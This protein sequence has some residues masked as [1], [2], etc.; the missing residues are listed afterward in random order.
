MDAI[1]YPK[2]SYSTQ[3]AFTL[4]ELLTVIAIIAILAVILIPTLGRVRQVTDKANCASNLRQ[5]GVGIITFASDNDG[6]LP[7]GVEPR[8]QWNL[9]GIQAYAGPQGWMEGGK[10]TQDLAAQIYRYVV[11]P[12]T[13]SKLP[14]VEVL[15]CP[16]NRLAT[17][18]YAKGNSLSSYHTGTGVVVTGG[19][20]KRPFGK[21]TGTRAVNMSEVVSLSRSVA[22]YDVDNEIQVN[23]GEN[24]RSDIPQHANEVHGNSRNFLYLD[25]HV[26]AQ[27]L[28]YKPDWIKW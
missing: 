19:E 16:G 17:D 28:D 20:I 8:G 18:A 15:V 24:A 23:L 27:P 4:I 3:S 7:G 13:S 22:L 5:V 9:Y 21:A 1:K 11:G 14:L 12:E 6:W 10:P 25:G 2:N 26:E